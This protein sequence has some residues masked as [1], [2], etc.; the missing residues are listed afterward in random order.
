VG[1]TYSKVISYKKVVK[2]FLAVSHATGYSMYQGMSKGSE[3][4]KDQKTNFK[5]L[6]YYNKTI[7]KFIIFKILKKVKGQSV[8]AD[9]LAKAIEGES[10]KSSGK[11]K[12][13]C[14]TNNVLRTIQNIQTL[15]LNK[16]KLI[17]ETN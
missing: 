16:L 11:S 4:T 1:T 2:K 8:E 9:L 15:S 3:N 10:S 17:N 14:S 13:H 7:I 12:E 5:R 6:K